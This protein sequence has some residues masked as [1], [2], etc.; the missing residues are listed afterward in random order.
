MPKYEK[1]IKLIV[2]VEGVTE[3]ILL[4]AFSKASGFDFAVKG[5]ELISS[6]GKN[7]II[8]LYRELS[9]ETQVPIFMIFDSDA[10]TLIDENIDIFRKQDEIFI[11]N[12]GEFEDILTDKLILTA[13]ND[14]Y[15]LTG[16]I[17]LFE[18]SKKPN[19]ARV[20]AD[21]YK[22]K[23]FGD[24]KKAEFAAILSNYIKDESDLSF[25]LKTLFIA[26]KSAISAN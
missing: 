5:I 24:F 19:K 18:I 15:R 23:G 6:G 12:G 8:R 13:L 10:A 9:Q 3:K 16:K 20:L 25:E 1:K 17:E 2:L 7:R 4:P 26:L 11:I 14:H 22:L 21:L